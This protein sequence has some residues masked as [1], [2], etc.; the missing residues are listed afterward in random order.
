MMCV[1]AQGTRSGCTATTFV[2]RW[3]YLKRDVRH[4]LTHAFQAIPGALVQEPQ[5]DVKGRAAPVL[6]T[7]RATQ[8]L[9]GGRGCLIYG[10]SLEG[11]WL[12]WGVGVGV[13]VKFQVGEYWWRSKEDRGVGTEGYNAGTTGTGIL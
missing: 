9:P 2:I 5:G 3:W 10:R 1:D 8:G 12:R 6:Q 11:G 13:C 4:R 7:E